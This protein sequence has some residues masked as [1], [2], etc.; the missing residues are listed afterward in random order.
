MS[1]IG[2]KLIVI[3][4]NVDVKIN[5]GLLEF[6]GK[7]GNLNLK[8]PPFI[9]ID[10]KDKTIIFTPEN[11]LKQTISNW[12]TIRALSNNAIIGLTQGFEK[13]LE[14]EGIGYSANMEGNTL[15]LNIG[16]SHP[17]KFI[18]PEGVKIFVEKN[19]IKISGLNKALVGET[20]AEIRAFRKPEPYKGKGIRYQKEIIRRKAGK[21]MAGTTAK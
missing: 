20:A 18:S 5:D 17:I 4:D 6:K 8:I 11:D 16:F 10:I 14:I 1:K 15:V 9:K 19:T 13:I 3:P 2:K 21:K 7:N 12:G